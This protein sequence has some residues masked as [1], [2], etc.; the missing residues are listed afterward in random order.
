MALRCTYLRRLSHAALPGNSVLVARIWLRGAPYY[1]PWGVA[2]L[3]LYLFF[4][5][6]VVK[7]PGV[8]DPRTI[9]R[10]SLVPN[11]KITFAKVSQKFLVHTHTTDTQRTVWKQ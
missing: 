11:L 10:K 4:A 5:K 8:G 3:G 9:S 1:A 7:V 6:F 2:S